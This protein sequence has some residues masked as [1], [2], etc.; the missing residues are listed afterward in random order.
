M[1]QEILAKEEGKTL[2]FKESANSLQ[3]II[4]TIIAFANTAGGT[5]VIGVEDRTKVVVGVA[6]PL[7][8]EMRIVNKVSE[9]I[10]PFFTPN[11]EIQ[12]YRKKALIII[13]VPYA[14]GPYYL[15]NNNEGIAYI[16][17]GSTNRIADADTI[18]TIKSL[19]R[20]TTFDE[21]PCSLAPK[22]AIDWESIEESF[23]SVKKK[24]TKHKAKSIGIFAT[25]SGVDHPSNGGIL[26]FGKDRSSIFPDAIIRCVRFSGLTRENSVDHIEI[27]EHLPTAVDEVL[28][29]I[30]KNTFTKTKIGKARR[31]NIP[32]YPPVAVREA[33]INAIVHAD[34]SI[35]GSSMIIA[36][37]DDRIEI[38]NPGS[39]PYGLTLEEALAGSSRARNRVIARTFHLLEF[40]EQWGSGLQKIIQACLKNGLQEPKFEEL[41]SQFRVTIY[42]AE[43]KKIA[44]EKWQ[45]EFM[46]YLHSLGELSAHDAAKL[47]KI[48]VRSA[49]RRLKKLV[50]EGLIA[51]IGISKND[52]YSKYIAVRSLVNPAE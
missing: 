15:E 17:F 13:Q 50:D 20:N 41:G 14:I 48:D 11:I 33:V 21:I 45:Q 30:K 51:K 38:T 34:Y 35:K 3:G 10:T 27:D 6:D 2:E 1:L 28:Y 43:I 37:F 24:M 29:F 49:R 31:V 25:Q 52:P 23:E 16:R 4:K 5:I 47:W 44:T 40:I 26:L 42:A 39:V 7:E 46:E 12:S 8:N 9:S 19:A 32:Q 36:I 22:D 18:A